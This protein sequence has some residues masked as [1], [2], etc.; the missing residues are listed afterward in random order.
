MCG[1]QVHACARE[2]D[3]GE[4]G[5]LVMLSSGCCIKIPP[6]LPVILHCAGRACGAFLL[7][8][9]NGEL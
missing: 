7:V 8:D 6:P 1:V 2:A 5:L 9:E 3:R 4:S